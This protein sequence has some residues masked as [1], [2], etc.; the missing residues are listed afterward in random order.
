MLEFT[1]SGKIVWGG[2]FFIAIISL[3][4]WL[5]PAL[6]LLIILIV[7]ASIKALIK[8]PGKI[9]GFTLGAL[10]LMCAYLSNGES[11]TVSGALMVIGVLIFII[12]LV[13]E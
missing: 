6:F 7:I 9:Y 12:T 2:L 3:N 1:T 11:H 8:K 10:A 4:Y 5:M 13:I